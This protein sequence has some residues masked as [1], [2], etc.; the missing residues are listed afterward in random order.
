MNHRELIGFMTICLIMIY[1]QLS[2]WTKI[3]QIYFDFNLDYNFSSF[4]FNSY[5]SLYDSTANNFEIS[6]M[7]PLTK[8]LKKLVFQYVKNLSSCALSYYQ[9]YF[10]VLYNFP[11]TRF[12]TN[13]NNINIL[14]VS[15]LHYSIFSVILL[16]PFNQSN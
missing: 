16:C 12:N 3:D 13:K 2:Y 15:L 1:L 5:I 7:Y 14:D 10:F 11:E 9:K 8:Q 4:Y 6:N